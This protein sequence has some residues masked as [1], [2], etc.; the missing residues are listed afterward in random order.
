MMRSLPPLFMTAP[1][2]NQFTL[3]PQYIAL[4]DKVDVFSTGVAARRG[5]DLQCRSGCA[6]CCHVELS[7]SAVEAAAIRERLAT[8]SSDEKA[9]LR[10]RLDQRKDHPVSGDGEAPRCVMLRDDDRCAI[11]TARPLVCRSQGLPLLYPAANIPQA[12]QR[13]QTADG[14]ALTICP[15]NFQDAPPQSADILDAERVDVLLALINRRF[16]EDAGESAEAASANRYALADLAQ[17]FVE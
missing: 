12:A 17:E 7:V 1:Q 16:A 9:Q 11:Y 3:P 6:G 8:L 15:L 13:G 10:A 14:R 2:K 5:D 4:R